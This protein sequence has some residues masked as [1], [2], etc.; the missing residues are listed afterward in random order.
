MMTRM[1][2][3]ASGLHTGPSAASLASLRGRGRQAP[4]GWGSKAAEGSSGRPVGCSLRVPRTLE[5][6]AMRP[7]VA[8]VLA[9]QHQPLQPALRVP[10]F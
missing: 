5:L 10:D 6:D 3:S 9:L 4:S 2:M 8:R 7:G 1:L